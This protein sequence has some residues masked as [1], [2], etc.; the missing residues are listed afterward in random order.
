MRYSTQ[1]IQHTFGEI[2]ATK[3]IHFIIWQT[4][5]AHSSS[6]ASVIMWYD[7]HVLIAVS[8]IIGK[9]YKSIDDIDHMR[10]V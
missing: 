5:I 4:H 10:P 9:Q 8:N 3:H 1:Y 2:I 6:N 7:K